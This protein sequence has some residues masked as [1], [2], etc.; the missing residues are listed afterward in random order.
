MTTR[1]IRSWPA[2]LLA[3][4]ACT[5]VAACDRPRDDRTAAQRADTTVA[6]AEQKTD[7]ARANVRE[8]ARDAKQATVNAADAAGDKVK[9]ATITMGVKSRL[10]AD[11]TLSALAIDV[12]TA[13]GRVALH[14][15]APDA[16]ARDRATQIAGQVDGVLSVE[17]QLTVASK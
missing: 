17:N 5:V 7:E 12:D 14:G 15:T 8:A 16:A 13:G 10:A 11:P 2:T 4:A 9:D 1:T 6:K 3:I